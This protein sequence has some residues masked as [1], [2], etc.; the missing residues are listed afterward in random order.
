MAII[1]THQLRKVYRNGFVAVDALDLTVT[2]GQVFGFLGPNG[3][4][5]TTTIGM[6]IGNV[7]PS[8]GSGTVL[9]QRLGHREARRQMGY[10]PEKFQFHDFL[11]ATEFL[12]LHGKLYGMDKARRTARIPEVLEQVGLSTR[13]KSRLKEF[14][15]GMQQRAGIAQAL[16]HEPRLV[17]LDEPTSALDPVGRRAVKEMILALK[18]KGTTIVINSHLLS[19]IEETCDAVAII[20]QG[21]VLKQGTIKAITGISGQVMIELEALSSQVVAVLAPLATL[22]VVGNT[23]HLTPFSGVN[24]PDL[25]AAIVAVGGRVQSVHTPQQTL[26]DVFVQLMS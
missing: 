25:V 2:E 5:K 4:G 20:R 11:T 1:E 24:V 8:G 7:F 15:R 17:I 23:L 21:V 9:G 26:E 13:A 3:A 18:A 12:D 19:E 16:L 14:S 22:K 6:L 10:L